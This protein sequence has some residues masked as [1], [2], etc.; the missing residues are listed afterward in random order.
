M[1]FDG[2]FAYKKGQITFSVADIKTEDQILNNIQIG[3]EGFIP[4]C[5]SH[6]DS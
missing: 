5:H 4:L 6:I 1:R 2:S 3:K